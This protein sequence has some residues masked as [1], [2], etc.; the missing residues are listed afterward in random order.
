MFIIIKYLIYSLY[1]EQSEIF[2]LN[3]DVRYNIN[4][5]DLVRVYNNDFHAGISSNLQLKVSEGSN[6][7]PG[8]NFF[9]KSKIAISQATHY[10][11]L[12]VYQ[13]DLKVSAMIIGIQ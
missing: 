5:Q 2:T 12:F 8:L 4:G 6:P 13:L 1:D 10:K 3:F 9:L 11:F 7:G